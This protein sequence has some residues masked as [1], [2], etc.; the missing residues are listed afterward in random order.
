VR[1]LGNEPVV[2]REAL[3]DA[4]PEEMERRTAYLQYVLLRKNSV[5]GWLRAAL[6]PRRGD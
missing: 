5:A 3:F 6:F 1:D 4:S 2:G